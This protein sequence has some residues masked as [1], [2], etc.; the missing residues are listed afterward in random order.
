MHL[1]PTSNPTEHSLALSLAEH[2]QEP[3]D[4]TRVARYTC[5]WLLPPFNLAACMQYLIL[6][7][8]ASI[9]DFP[10]TRISDHSHAVYW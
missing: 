6:R 7:S 4:C 3:F 8:G 5:Q 10:A 2:R 9:W 1:Y